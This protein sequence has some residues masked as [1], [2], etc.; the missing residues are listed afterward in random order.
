LCT[1]AV[2]YGAL[3]NDTGRVRIKWSTSGLSGS[4]R[5]KMEWM[6][7]GGPAVTRPGRRGFGSRLIERGLSRDLR[8]NARLEFKSTGLRCLIEAPLEQQVPT[9]T[10]SPSD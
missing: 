7:T 6:E 4:R 2:K 8:G 5:L 9:L 1:N 3:S 10:G